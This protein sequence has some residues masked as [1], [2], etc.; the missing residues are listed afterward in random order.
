MRKSSLA[1]LALLLAS[2]GYALAQTA[3]APAVTAPHTTG[4]VAPSGTDT[5]VTSVPGIRLEPANT[6]LPTVDGSG[7]NQSGDT[8]NTGAVMP[9]AGAPRLPGVPMNPTTG[10]TTPP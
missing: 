3:G 6:P 9:P 4:A 8:S 10:P 7:V 1:A 2:P 5:P